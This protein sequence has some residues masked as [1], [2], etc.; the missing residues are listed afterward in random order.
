[1]NYN[2]V[3]GALFRPP[4]AGVPTPAPVAEAR[5][6]RRLRDAIEPLAMHD[7]WCRRTNERLAAF[8]LDFLG[9]YVWGRAAALGEPEAGVVVAAF[10]VF[11][12]G[13]IT[14]T[15]ERARGRVG[16]AALIAARVEATTASLRETLGDADVSDAVAVLRRGLDAAEGAGRPLF[17]GLRSLAW[18]EEP[19]GQ[20]WRACDLLREHRGDSHI[21]AC[22]SAGLDP[23]TMNILTELWVGMPLGSYTATRGW[24]PEAI[25]AS[26]ARLAADGL[27]HGGALTA[28]GREFRDRIEERTD[29]QEQPVVDAIGDDF[30]RVATQLNTW[31]ARCIE[32][33][34]FPPDTLKRAAG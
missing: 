17:S 9:S 6:P 28:A 24:S 31:S 15:Y 30:E 2:D 26:A 11:E 34:A 21:A 32:A 19:V 8:G 33:G 25:A 29:A 22:I 7:I 1:M 10:A 23:V 14:A 3:V 18:P 12:P 5:P 16:R 4:P 27:V 13:L 20:L